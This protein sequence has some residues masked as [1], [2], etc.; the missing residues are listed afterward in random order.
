MIYKLNLIK[1]KDKLIERV[2]Y[3]SMKELREFYG[4]NWTTNTP[5]I[6]L[7]KDRKSIDLFG[8]RKTEPWLVAWADY[9]M[10]T[11]FVL[12]KK[13]LERQS[14]HKYSEKYYSCLMKH[15]LSHL[16]YK[17]LSAGKSGPIWLSEGVA[18]Y[19]SGQNSLKPKSKPKEFKNFLTF[20]N[21]GGFDVYAESGFVIETLV[22]KFGKNKL[23]ELIKSLK[24]VSDKKQFNKVFQ[25]I[26]R[27]QINYK[28][29]N[30]HYLKIDS[31][32]TK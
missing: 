29:I 17:I 1:S 26:Y 12:D 25:K 10:Q 9:G 14:S 8:I 24:N 21:Q 11:V 20:H 4:I 28:E 18:I 22:K 6:F 13:N 3:K 32:V 7:L 15:E 2:F 5:K 30:R 16:F 23:L 19:T 31:F 27:F